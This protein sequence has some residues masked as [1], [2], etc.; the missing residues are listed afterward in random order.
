MKSVAKNLF[1]QAYRLG[2]EKK[3]EEAAK[4]YYESIQADFNFKRSH[5][6][7][8]VNLEELQRYQEASEWYYFCFFKLFLDLKLIFF[9]FVEKI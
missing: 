5:M 2:E 7:L 3:F 6:N 8:G 9:K 4:L 1:E